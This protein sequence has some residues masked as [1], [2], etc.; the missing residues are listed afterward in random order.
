[1]QNKKIMEKIINIGLWIVIVL[2]ILSVAYAAS[3]LH[4]ILAMIIILL[5]LLFILIKADQSNDKSTKE[6]S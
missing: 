1:M 3:L 2:L 6:H 5:S 4:W